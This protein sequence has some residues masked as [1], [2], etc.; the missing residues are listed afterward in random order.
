MK[1]WLPVEIGFD[2][3]PAVVS[4][5][6]VRWMEFGSTPLAEPFFDDTVNKLR[7]AAPP[8]PEVETDIETM[9]R[10]SSG[11][12]AVRPAGFI[13]HISR[14]GSTLVAN[15]LKTADEVAVVSESR[16]LMRLLL[17]SSRPLGRYLNARW[18][19]TRRTIIDSLF[20]LFAHYRTGE[21]ERLVIKFTS[22]N[23]LCMSVVRACWPDV[24]CVV[25]VRDPVEVMVASL[26]GGGWMSLKDSPELARQIFGWTDLPVSLEEMSNEEYCARVLGRFFA[27]AIESADSKCR[28]VDYEDLSANRVRDIAAFFGIEIPSRSKD[29]D[30]VFRRYAKDP[31]HRQPF[32]ADREV[33]QRLASGL[34]RSAARQWAMPLYSELRGRKL[35]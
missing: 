6:S 24:P 1:G 35:S 34:V 26:G 5:A 29:L 12:A 15:G 17:P 10:V 25:V 22:I 16:P 8:A 32:Q 14:C 33:K 7:Q 19:H 30:Q 31:N 9:L 20:S 28:V 11:L 3:Q 18:D 27:S 23:I 2:P 4:E 13:F 21:P